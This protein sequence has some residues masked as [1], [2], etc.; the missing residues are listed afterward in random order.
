MVALVFMIIG[1]AAAL[2]FTSF[3]IYKCVKLVK[4]P[5]P[6]A[7]N[8]P[9]EVKKLACFN[10]AIAVAILLTFIM[11]SVY[12]GYALK[13]G[14][15]A[16]LVIGSLIFGLAFPSSIHAFIIHYYGKEIPVKLNKG[17]F[18]SI[19]GGLLVSGLGLLIIT[20]SIA[21][22]VAYPLVNGIS[23]QKGFTVPGGVKPSIAWYAICILGG[24]V[25]VYFICDHRFYV[26]YGKHGILESTFLVAFP[27]GIIG[28][29]IGYVIGNWNRTA[30]GLSF[31]QRVANGEW[32]SPLAIWEGGLTIITGALVGII[33]G[34][35]WF[36]WRNKKYSIWLAVDIIVPTI[37]V[38]QAIGRWGNFFNAEVHGFEVSASSW[39]WFLPKMVLNNMA[40]SEK[41][42]PANP[43]MIYLPLFYIEF[44]SNLAGYFF[45]RFALGKGLRKYLQLGDLAFSY[46]VWYGLTRVIM[47]PM[48]SHAYNMGTDNFYS[49]IWA[50]VFVVA[51]CFAIFVNHLVRYLINKKKESFKNQSV[52]GSSI[53]SGVLLI[54]SLVFIILG[55]IYMQG[56]RTDTMMFDE[57]NT[58]LL[59][60]IIGLGVLAILG[61]SIIYLIQGLSRKH[62]TV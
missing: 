30:E 14:E 15:W 61:C 18:W 36:I 33:I 56:V 21:D 6:R 34:V 38:A 24:A 10:A 51:G 46:I 45:I 40:F 2:G 20:N 39:R 60:L 48:R 11:L 29:R 47:E 52:L 26:E 22:Y 4:S 17:L 57:F 35:L 41:L 5:T 42:G 1:I 28:A 59:L 8:Y 13:A 50:M 49:W 32:W 37:L 58:G 19:I 27:A 55:A 9:L 44:L 16:A 23:F 54:A 7:N 12:Q 62:E 31:A 53:S 25:L 3:G 43:G